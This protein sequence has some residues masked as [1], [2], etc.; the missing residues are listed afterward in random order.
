[1]SDGIVPKA[2]V[3]EELK[4]WFVYDRPWP[5]IMDNNPA[6]RPEDID[7]DP[8]SIWPPGGVFAIPSG[9]DVRWLPHKREATIHDV[10]TW[11]W[12]ARPVDCS[13]FWVEA[14][15]HKMEHDLYTL[16]LMAAG[17]IDKSGIMDS[18][19][20][21]PASEQI[22]SFGMDRHTDPGPLYPWCSL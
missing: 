20:V 16:R 7:N 12:P 9:A 11:D 21:P 5:T 3:E 6:T 2:W 22:G 17:W 8:S 18:D 10:V 19:R 15:P 1:M 14:D 13:H 4:P